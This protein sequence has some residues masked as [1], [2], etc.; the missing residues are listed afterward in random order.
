VQVRGSNFEP[1]ITIDRSYQPKVQMGSLFGSQWNDGIAVASNST[2]G[3]SSSTANLN[4]RDLILARDAANALAQRNG[5]NAQESRLY[6]TYTD[7]SNYERGFF[8]WSAN[9]LKIG[10]EAAGTGTVRELHISG[11]PTSN[12]GAGILW[13][14]A[15]TVK[16]GT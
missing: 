16:V 6:N 1:T 9:A 12:P 15:G 7:A 3:F 4:S 10:T 11:L 8:R 13:N 14:D 2:I 5:T